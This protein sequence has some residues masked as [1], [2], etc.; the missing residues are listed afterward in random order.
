M[1]LLVARRETGLKSL[2]RTISR[3]R[4]SSSLP[5][6]YGKESMVT[7]SATTKSLVL[8]HMLRMQAV[9]W[10][11]DRRR[12]MWR[13]FPESSYFC[14]SKDHNLMTR[15]HTFDEVGLYACTV[16]SMGDL[17]NSS[18]SAFDRRSRVQVEREWRRGE[19]QFQLRQAQVEVYI[20]YSKK[21]LRPIWMINSPR[22]Q[23]LENCNW[24]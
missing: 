22:R 24:N 16:V 21:F 3:F 17:R 4:A 6:W 20:L 14:A 19:K 23:R 10:R 8:A 18:A 7:V 1:S 2:C 13:N 11:D 12:W 9:K 5:N 15:L